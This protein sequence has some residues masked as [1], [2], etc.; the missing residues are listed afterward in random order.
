MTRAAKEAIGLPTP[1]S[2]KETSSDSDTEEKNKENPSSPEGEVVSS[3]V[4]IAEEFINSVTTFSNTYQNKE[5][6]NKKASPKS[7]TL[8]GMKT[9]YQQFLTAY[10]G[11][12]PVE[13]FVSGK[14]KSLNLKI[15][16]MLEDKSFE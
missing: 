14:N 6:K 3:L 7:T 4:S 10:A 2:D 12:G 13:E 11:Q 1:P 5:I 8:L 16:K 9:T 15:L